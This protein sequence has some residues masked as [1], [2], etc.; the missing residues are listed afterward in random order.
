MQTKQTREN[1]KMRKLTAVAAVLLVVLAGYGMADASVVTLSIQLNDTQLSVDGLNGP[2]STTYTV[3]GMVTDN[4]TD[5]TFGVSINGGLVSFM[6]DQAYSGTGMI[7]HARATSP[8]T[9]YTAATTIQAP[10]TAL[11]SKGSLLPATSTNPGSLG[12]NNIQGGSALPGDKYDYYTSAAPYEYGNGTPVALYTGSIIALA[13]GTVTIDVLPEA[14]QILIWQVDESGLK[15]VVPTTVIPAQ[16]VV[17]VGSIGPVTNPATVSITTGNVLEGDWSDEGGWNNP[18][19]SVQIDAIGSAND[20]GQ[21]LAWLWQITNNN[22]VTKNLAADS[23]SFALTIGELAALFAA[24]GGLPGPYNA[25]DDLTAYNWS[26]KAT[27]TDLD[28][29]VASAPISVFVPE[30]TTI[31]LLGFGIISAILKRRRRA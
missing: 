2:T 15:A 5:D 10:F 30:P 16:A 14:G 28:G 3:Y 31:G 12:V 25:G 22:G 7:K 13:D 19:H 21:T 29:S 26:L 20:E 1:R 17:T 8:P 4:L 24:D 27:V 6:T 18:L 9:V 11:T 23:G